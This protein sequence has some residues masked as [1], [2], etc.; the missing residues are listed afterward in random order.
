MAENENLEAVEL[1]LAREELLYVLS[2]FS[3]DTIPGIEDDP[4]GNLTPE[5][6]A[7]ALRVAERA[8]RARQLA[9]LRDD[10][11]LMLH[12][13]LLSAVGAC[14][15]SQSALMIYHWQAGQTLPTPFFV[16]IREGDIVVH[17][18]PADVLHQFSRFPASADLL[19]QVLTICEYRETPANGSYETVLPGPLLGQAQEM[20]GNGAKAPAVDLLA[21]NGFSRDGAQALVNT[22]AAENRASNLQLAKQK[23]G[24]IHQQDYLLL[25]DE[26]YTWLVTSE[27][28]DNGR[29][30][31]RTATRPDVQ[32]LIT[33]W[34][35]T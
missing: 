20:A 15:Y 35:A 3:V 29:V 18:R 21:A 7:V 4:A 31:I 5:Q 11:Q 19:Q 22:L 24:Q 1:L 25:Q 14:A 13:D 9:W 33:E 10:G 32:G 23:D 26:Q 8:L 27:N 6:Q 16:H 2:L 28:A 17:T 34:M 12:N 30:T